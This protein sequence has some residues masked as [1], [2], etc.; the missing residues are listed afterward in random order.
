[1]AKNP[2]YHLSKFDGP[3]DLL[4]F[5]I[6]KSEVNIYDIPI[7]EITDQYI[8]YLELATGVDLE[9]LTEFYV[10]AS[11]LLYI[12]SRMLLPIEVDIDD[13]MIEDPRKE[14]VNQLID[15]QKYKKLAVLME[16]GK[17]DNEWFVEREKKQLYFSFENEQNLWKK[18]EVWDLVKCFSRIVKAV[19]FTNEISL[20]E[21]ITINEKV[22]LIHEYIDT[23]REFYFSDLL[24]KDNKSVLEVV[25]CFLAVLESIKQ[26]TISVYQNTFFGD[27]KITGS[28]YEPVEEERKTNQEVNDDVR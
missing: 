16:E 12:K 3:L 11:T 24:N 1:M 18:V 2:E 20:Y 6:K 22:T 8:E 15:Y 28:D 19:G 5:L 25:C 9:Y 14:I 4:L 26:K 23:R 17:Q 7:S 10:L 21:E 13:I 27:I